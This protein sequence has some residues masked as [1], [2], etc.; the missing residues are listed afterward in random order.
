MAV[1]SKIFI[2]FSVRQS[3][4]KLCHNNS[5]HFAVAKTLAKICSR[6]WW[7]TMRKDTK[8][9]VKGCEICEQVNGRTTLAMACL[10]HNLYQQHLLRSF[11][12]IIY[13]YQ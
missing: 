9:Y 11:L 8:L 2:P 1:K 12:L 7:S 4:L 5:G 13:L 10:D 3:V 6:Y